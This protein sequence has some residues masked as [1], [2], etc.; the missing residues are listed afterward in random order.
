MFYGLITILLFAGM[1]FYFRVADRYNIIDKPN[2]RSS[3]TR[4]TIRGG[5]VVF[6][7]G[8]LAWFIWS[9]GAYPYFFAGLTAI[10]LISFLDDMLTLSNRVRI[11]VHFVPTASIKDSHPSRLPHPAQETFLVR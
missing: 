4:V 5:G 3:H 10:M 7:L 6:Y 2:E 8:A 11:S 9:G 1:L